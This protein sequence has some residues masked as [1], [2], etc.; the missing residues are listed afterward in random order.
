MD[1]LGAC[2][3]PRLVKVVLQNP[4]RGLGTTT[5]NMQHNVFHQFMVHE[6]NRADSIL[7]CV[8]PHTP[9]IT[10]IKGHFYRGSV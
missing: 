5:S 1:D 8:K 2:T 9:P 4:T 3:V 7:Q 6:M 10:E